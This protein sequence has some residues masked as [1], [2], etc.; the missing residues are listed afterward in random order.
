M[1]QQKITDDKVDEIVS[2]EVITEEDIEFLADWVE[3]EVQEIKS[4]SNGEQ[5]NKK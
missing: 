3:Q 5:P 4:T 2:K 1:T